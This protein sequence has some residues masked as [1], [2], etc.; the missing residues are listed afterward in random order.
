MPDS[1]HDPLNDARDAGR[2]EAEAFEATLRGKE[3]AARIDRMT[4]LA[5]SNEAGLWPAEQGETAPTEVARLQAQVEALAD[6]RAA[7]LGSQAWRAIQ[8]VRRIFG[9]AW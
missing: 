5:A 8:S 7:V 4:R 3:D 2:A 6:F 9:R 1:T